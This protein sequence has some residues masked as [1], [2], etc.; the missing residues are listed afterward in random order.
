VDSYAR[1]GRNATGIAQYDSLDFVGKWIELL[2]LAA[3]SARRMAFLWQDTRPFTVS[4]KAIDFWSEAKASARK[5]GF[6]VTI[7]VAQKV[8]DVDAMLAEAGAARAQVAFI[9]G[10]P[11]LGAGARVTEY[12][13]RQRWISTTLHPNCF[14]MFGLLMYYGAYYRD[15]GGWHRV[16]E[17]ADRILRGA[18][19]AEIP[20]EL[21]TRYELILNTKTARA[22][23]L[24]LPPS[25]LLRADWVV[26]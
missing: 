8:E 21:P 11:Y 19:V 26:E 10:T 5:A 6:E 20:V 1:P 16:R 15:D 18:H 13:L 2:R 17:I 25:L 3:P 22:L 24:T 23:G 9:T 7:H 12:A 4:G 14:E